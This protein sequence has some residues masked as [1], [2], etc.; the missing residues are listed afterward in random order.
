MNQDHA[1][2]ALFTQAC[3]ARGLKK[4]SSTLAAL[5]GSGKD[6]D[7]VEDLPL[8]DIYLG[9]RGVMALLD[10]VAQAPNFRKLDLSAQKLYNS[11]LSPDAVKGNEVV[12]RVVEVSQTHPQMTALDLSHNPLSNFAGRKLLQL[13]N[14]NEKVR[15]RG[16]G[17]GEAWEVLCGVGRRQTYT[18]FLFIFPF[19]CRV[20]R[21]ECNDQHTDCDNRPG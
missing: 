16:K 14:H 20:R 3:K 13:V 21:T 4:P 18:F 10:V 19:V 7:E 15:E 2:V 12:D 8:D 11:D 6:L 17:E 9:T 5:L 1:A